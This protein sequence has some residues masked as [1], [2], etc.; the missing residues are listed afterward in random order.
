MI[1]VERAIRR[2]N[3]WLLCHVFTPQNEADLQDQVVGVLIDM[4]GVSVEREVVAGASRY[5]L[6]VRIDDIK[7]VLELKVQGSAAAVERQAQRYALADGVDAV[8]VVTTK[9]AL[10]ARILQVGGAELGGKPFAVIALRGF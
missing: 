7:L 10:A 6:L 5:D 2:I 4:A 8:V 1:A 9:R 3:A